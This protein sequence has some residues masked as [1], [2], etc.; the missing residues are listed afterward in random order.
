[1]GKLDKEFELTIDRMHHSG[2]GVGRYKN[3]SIFVFG[4]MVGERVLVRPTKVSRGKAKAQVLQILKAAPD[5]EKEKEDHYL[6]CSPWQIINYQKQLEYKLDLTKKL[7]KNEAGL[8]PNTDVIIV[9]SK[10]EWHYRNKM[11]FSFVKKEKG[12]I[13]LAFHIRGRRYDCYELDACVLAGDKLSKVASVI[14]AILNER[15]I[16]IGSLKNLVLRYSQFE[17][18][19]L[20]S[21]YVK[22]E[23]FS[24]FDLNLDGI[25]G[26]QIIYSDPQ[27]PATVITKILHQQGRDYLEE[28]IGSLRLRYR[29]NNF[30]QINPPLFG[31]LLDFVKDDIKK[32]GDLIDLYA[33]VGTIGMALARQFNNIISVELDD[34]AVQIAKENIALNDLQ[35]ITLYSGASEKQDLNDI[36]SLA[37]TLV[38]DPPRSG[39]HPKVI[40][41]ILKANLRQFVYVSC[42]PLTQAKDMHLLKQ[43]YKVK[44]WRLFDL[45]PQTPHL[46]SVLILRRKIL[47]IF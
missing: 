26:W 12:D 28:K 13:S 15:H 41:A 47:G 7:F 4:A 16:E 19:C 18:K 27:S 17:D 20:V 9:R 33:G 14:V 21:L 1:M 36:F 45:Y 29:Y 11:E 22:D 30:F 10:K 43:K 38:V 37:K 32:G 31:E 40:K 39:L 3:R 6:S 23:N 5:R 46:E 34:T 42:N 24:V 2:E 8:I 25:V 44:K 35:N